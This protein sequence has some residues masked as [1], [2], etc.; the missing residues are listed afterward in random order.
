MANH[1]ASGHDLE[2]LSIGVPIHAVIKVKPNAGYYREDIKI[3]GDRVGLLDV[4]NRIREEYECPSIYDGSVPLHKLFEEEFPQYI[5]AILE[6]INISVIAFGTT[7]SGKTYN[8]EGDGGGDTGLLG[9]VVKA[10]FENLEEKRY[11]LNQ[12]KA[13]SHGYNFSV[14]LRYVE[15]VDE[16]MSDLLVQA[17]I[18]AQGTLQIIHDEWEGPAVLNASWMPCASAHHLVDMFSLARRNRTQ[19]V[20][21]SGPLSERSASFVTIEILQVTQSPSSNEASALASRV[22]IVDLPGLEKLHDDP[23]TLKIIIGLT[24]LAVFG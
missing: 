5:R 10:L 12:G 7:G 4:N 16:E 9:H 8:A 3:H 15:V 14:K 11:R 1:Y 2:Q 20:I 23:E 24:Q 6:G 19:A 18:R 21:E 17:N 13:Q 22:T